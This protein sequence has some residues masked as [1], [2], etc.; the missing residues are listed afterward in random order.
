[1]V[2]PFGEIEEKTLRVRPSYTRVIFGLTLEQ[3]P[4]YGCA[5]VTD[6]ADISNAGYVFSPSKAT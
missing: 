4:N 5:Y 6:V 1:M 3:D 2:Y